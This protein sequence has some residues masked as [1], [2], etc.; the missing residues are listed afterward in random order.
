MAAFYL[1][2]IYLI[3]F[4][5]TCYRNVTSS[6]KANVKPKILPRATLFHQ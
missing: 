3:T 1:S 6:R 5:K 2:Y 4:R